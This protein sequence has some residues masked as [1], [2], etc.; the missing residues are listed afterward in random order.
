MDGASLIAAFLAWSG[1]VI[2]TFGYAGVFVVSV[3]STAT[4]FLP[5]PG[6][7]FIVAAGTVSSLNPWLVAIISGAGMAIGELTG[8]ALGRGGTKALDRGK[9]LDKGKQKWLKRGEGW[10]RKG[11]G[12]LFILIFAATPLPDDVTGI[13]GGMFNYDIKKFLLATFIGKV[14]MNIV[15]VF[16]GAYGAGVVTGMLAA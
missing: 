2:G 10:F 14:L 12:F 16:A 5:I 3:I 15:L 13:L 8:Y 9:M 7:L 4:I 1:G 6:F 11:R